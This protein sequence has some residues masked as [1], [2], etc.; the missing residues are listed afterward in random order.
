[1][2]WQQLEYFLVVARLQHMTEAAKR[3]SISQPALSRSIAKLEQ[4]LG[5]PLFEREGRN[6]RLNRYGERFAARV[7]QALEAVRLGKEELRDLT[8]PES[9]TIV[10]SFL[11][12]LGLSVFPRLMSSFLKEAPRAQFQLYQQSTREML[13]KLE[14][15]EIDFA[16]SSMTESRNGIEWRFLW[17]EELFA[18]VPVDHSLACQDAIDIV[19]LSEER[20]IA[21]KP[22]YGLR[23]ITDRLFNAA[24][25]TPT[26]S[27]EA[28][29]VVSVAG[30]V[31]AGLGVTLLPRL[32]ELHED[33]LARIRV[34]D[35]ECR[36][37]IGLAWKK[38]G[39]L[40]PAAE[41]FR[42]FLIKAYSTP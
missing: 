24:G 2:E 9:G 27:F 29:E 15:S 35:P 1:M 12:S 22:G 23:T 41:R 10:V 14:R 26:I 3:L 8:D 39:Y 38:D 25:V 33:K 16:L 5:V 18:Y 32:P 21:V 36:R 20:F 30:F 31:A 37:H 42:A 6:I 28:E 40:S 13:D 11:K 4:E 19:A 7:E 17:E 34:T